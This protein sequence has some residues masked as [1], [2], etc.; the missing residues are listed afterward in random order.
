MRRH[1]IAVPVL[2]TI[3]NIEEVAGGMG[4]TRDA[5]GARL[6]AGLGS[7][8]GSQDAWLVAVVLITVIPWVLVL[9]GGLDRPNS[10]VARALVVLQAGMT[11]NVLSHVGG[12][13]AVRGYAG[14]VATAVLLYVPFSLRFFPRAWR[15]EWVT[16]QFLRWSPAL[17]LLLVPLLFAL[18]ALGSVITK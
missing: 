13:M 6:P 10:G 16:R 1:L 7:L 4:A 11:L 9:L 12:A 14:G 18:L 17:A 8:V 15:E 5:I 3:H 2:L